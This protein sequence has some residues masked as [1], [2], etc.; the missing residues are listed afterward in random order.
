[1]VH[2]FDF[3]PAQPVHRELTVTALCS[4]L[5]AAEQVT[6]GAVFSLDAAR[7]DCLSRAT[8]Q[9]KPPLDS[10]ALWRLVS[11]LSLNHAPLSLESL[12][13]ELRILSDGTAVRQILG[14]CAVSVAP[15]VRRIGP[16]AWRGFCRG[17]EVTLTF[18]EDAFVG[19][20]AF[21]FGAVL[22]RYL[23]QRAA[24]NSF[25]QVA[26]K[27]LQREGVWKKWAPMSGDQA[28]P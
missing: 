27:S 22:N 25:I 23:A 8:P 5:G 2:D 13:D 18:D 28:V 16:D 17:R 20:S 10:A 6:P 24:I 3:S 7:A 26:I 19:G 9:G 12:R 4:N 15:V 21:L 1:M 11:L 14:L